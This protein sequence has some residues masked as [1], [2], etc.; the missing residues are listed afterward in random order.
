MWWTD[1]GYALKNNILGKDDWVVVCL[2]EYLMIY[3]GPGFL[4]D[5]LFGPR[6][7]PS[8]HFPISKLPLF[9]NLP[10]CRRSSLLTGEKE[11]VG[12]EPNHTTARKLGPL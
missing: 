4:A 2:R 11:G 6:P 8:L 1:I 3:R 9:R 5:L 12:V 7:P 10:V